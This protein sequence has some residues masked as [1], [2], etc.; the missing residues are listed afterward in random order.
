MDTMILDDLDDLDDLQQGRPKNQPV[1]L[2]R[3]APNHTH[4]LTMGWWL[5]WRLLPVFPRGYPNSWMLKKRKSDQH[6]W[7][8]GTPILGNHH[9]IKLSVSVFLFS[10]CVFVDVCIR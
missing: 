1:L 4:D 6:G 5:S 10:P 2:D 9:L 3:K 8:G 7:F